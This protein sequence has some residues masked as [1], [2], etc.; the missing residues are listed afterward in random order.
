MAGYDFDK[1]LLFF[2]IETTEGTD[3]TPV[4]AD[5]IVTRGLQ[6]VTPEADVR[7]RN[8]DGQYFGA[9]PQTKSSI[10]G[11]TGF[12][13]EI[14]GGGAATTVPPWMKLLRVCGLDAGTVGGSSVVQAPISASIP[15]ATL[16]DYTDTLKQPVNGA[17]G[18]AR[19]TFE[20]DQYPFF[21]LDMLGYI[22]STP[23]TDAS[24]ATPDVSAFQAPVLVNNDNTVITLDGYALEVRRVEFNLGSIIVPRSFVGSIDRV[25]YRNR[26]MTC[27]IIAKCPTLASKNYFGNVAP[28]TQIDLTV[29]HGTSA[30]HI[31]EV[32]A[33]TMEVGVITMSDEEGD[34]MVNIPGRLVPTDAGND[35][36][37]ITTS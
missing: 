23:V 5:A 18:N 36:L 10:R 14:A 22:P 11:R 34:V 1:R 26:E 29:T 35:E 13:V 24:P 7:T 12:E 4:A 15:S 19:L 2:E 6:P 33:P 17:R 3:P 8:I 25:K 20:D 32:N 27:T 28:S 21:S 30:G 31:I 16:W 37:T 9:R